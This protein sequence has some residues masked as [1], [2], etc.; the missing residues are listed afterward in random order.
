MRSDYIRATEGVS[1]LPKLA[2]PSS[3]SFVNRCEGFPNPR[4]PGFRSLVRA[5]HPHFARRRRIE[6]AAALPDRS[7]LPSFVA[8]FLF[9]ASGITTPHR[10]YSMYK[11]HSTQPAHFR[12]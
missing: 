5:N 6:L 7:S 8:R 3:R 11:Y 10:P 1:S 4:D 12:A 2:N 9:I